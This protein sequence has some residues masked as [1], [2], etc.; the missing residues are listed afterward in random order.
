MFADGIRVE[1]LRVLAKHRVEEGIRACVDYL[2]SQ[3]PWGSQERTPELTKI[4]VSY[5]ARAKSV[6][7]DLKRMAE[8]FAAGE[9]DFPKNLSLQKAAA[10]REAIREIEASNDQPE[11]IR[12]N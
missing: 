11:L 10:V 1:G 5:G 12:I 2:R 3:N 4:L 6:V 8:N 9:P 7:P